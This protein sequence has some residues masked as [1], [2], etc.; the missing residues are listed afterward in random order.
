MHQVYKIFTLSFILTLTA[1]VSYSQEKTDTT[2]TSIDADLINIFSQKTPKKY[3]INSIKLPAIS[4][5]MK[6]FCFQLQV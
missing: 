5:L 1:F 4:T 2:I 6:T 3:K